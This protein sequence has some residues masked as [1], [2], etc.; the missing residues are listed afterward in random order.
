MGIAV[1]AV[2]EEELAAFLGCVKYG[3]GQGELKDHRH[4]RRGRVNSPAPWTLETVSVP[5]ARLQ[6]GSGH[7]SEWR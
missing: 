6:D 4:G 3:R 7:S 1:E 2:F 5:R